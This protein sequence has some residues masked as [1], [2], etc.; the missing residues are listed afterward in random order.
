MRNRSVIIRKRR[1]D[2]KRISIEDKEEKNRTRKKKK[3]KKKNKK[4]NIKKR[5]K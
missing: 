5:T 4:M 2:G 1:T 3:S